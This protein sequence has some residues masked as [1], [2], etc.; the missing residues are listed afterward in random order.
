MLNLI[1]IFEIF[2]LFFC[3]SLNI[4]CFCLNSL[5][6][7][8]NYDLIPHWKVYLIKRTFSLI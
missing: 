8:V 1:Y 6:M 7:D 3:I 5:K 4:L 2:S